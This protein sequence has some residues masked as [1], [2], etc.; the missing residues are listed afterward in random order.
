MPYYRLFYHL[1]WA[2][3]NRLALIEPEIEA[4]L[5]PYL[6]KKSDEIDCRMLAGN[7]WTDHVHLVM[8]V[9]PRWSI[10]EVV[11]RLKGSSAHDF[12]EL[13]WQRGYGALTV[14]ERSLDIALNYVNQQKDHHA[15]QTIILRLERCGDDL[16]EPVDA[17]HE[18]QSP[19]SVS[20]EIPF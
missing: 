12:S 17:V 2:T 19:Y 8:A 18:S 1:I 10:S 14:G 13:N 3:K 6:K 9:P 4:P 20:E 15:Q 7:G 11:K 16:D 5:Y